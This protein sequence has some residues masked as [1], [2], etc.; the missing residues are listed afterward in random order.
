MVERKGLTTTTSTLATSQ[1]TLGV[2]RSV[3][4]FL[5]KFKKKQRTRYFKQ[6]KNVNQH[7]R[8]N[9]YSS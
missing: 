9:I 8:M 7:S 1:V 2:F 3:V 4:I 6:E 5:K